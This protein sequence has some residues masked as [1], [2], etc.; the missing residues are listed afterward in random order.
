MNLSRDMRELLALFKEHGVS[1]VLVGGFAVNYYGYSRLTQD[2]DFLIL[3][4]AENAGRMMKVLADFGFGEA[5]IPANCFEREGT[6][7][8][9]GVEP[10]RID[11]LT[12]LQGVSNQQ[13]FEHARTVDFDGVRLDV[14]AYEDLLRVKK[15]SSRARDRADAEELEKINKQR[16]P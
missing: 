6:A 11:F 15:S 7:I 16:S 5:G 8:H 1:Y 13:L 14:I 4:S 10:N 9:L 2:I 3:P 12:S